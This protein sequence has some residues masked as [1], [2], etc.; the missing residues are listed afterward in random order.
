MNRQSKSQQSRNNDNGRHAENE[1]SHESRESTE[2]ELS[3]RQQDP[4]FGQSSG[5]DQ[6]R[7]AQ[8]LRDGHSQQGHGWQ[9][10]GSGRFDN[11]QYSLG[12]REQSVRSTG[13]TTKG[14]KGYI[15][16]DER[17]RDDVA[18]RLLDAHER[19]WS[20]VEVLVAGGTV[21]LSG[22]VPNRE[23]RWEVE[24]LTEGVRGVID[25]ENQVRV[26]RQESS[27]SSLGMKSQAPS[28]S[29]KSETNGVSRDSRDLSS[30]KQATTPRN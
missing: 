11:G 6:Y 1:H 24:Q 27:E 25:I 28:T 4:M 12:G 5:S 3:A 23:M 19:D 16:S 10:S 30:S 21:T 2:R 26:K 7:G 22:T 17:I 9:Q 18:D 15:R 29:G 20:D 14:P 8:Y 13:Q